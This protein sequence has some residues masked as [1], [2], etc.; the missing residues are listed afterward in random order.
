[1]IRAHHRLKGGAV[2][3]GAAA[4]GL[5]GPFGTWPPD[6]VLDDEDQEHAR[7]VGHPYEVN[8]SMTAGHHDVPGAQAG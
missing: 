3:L 4:P 6:G 5:P 8:T 7:A 2:Q 1:V